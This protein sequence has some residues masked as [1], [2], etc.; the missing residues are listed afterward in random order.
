MLAHRLATQLST[1]DGC[2]LL[3]PDIVCLFAFPPGEASPYRLICIFK[4]SALL[5]GAAQDMRMI[6][7][8]LSI[9]ASINE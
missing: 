8:L 4:P 2:V 3:A 1:E 6:A 7:V 5:H 9:T